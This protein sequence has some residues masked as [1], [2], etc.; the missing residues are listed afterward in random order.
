M[1]IEENQRIKLSKEEQIKLE[2]EAD[3]QMVERIVQKEQQL[4]QY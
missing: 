2:K 3:R 1:V 4:A